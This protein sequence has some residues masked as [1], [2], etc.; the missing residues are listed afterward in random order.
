MDGC[1]RLSGSSPGYAVFRRDLELKC[2][3]YRFLVQHGSAGDD[4]NIDSNADN[5]HPRFAYV[6]TAITVRVVLGRAL[7]SRIP[8]RLPALADI[9]GQ[10]SV[11]CMYD[12]N[13]MRR[14]GGAEGAGAETAP[15]SI[16]CQ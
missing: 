12:P 15:L 5:Q 11:P 9:R 14:K 6:G 3:M 7:N 4:D 13:T 8:V 16:T 1:A 10:A 2:S